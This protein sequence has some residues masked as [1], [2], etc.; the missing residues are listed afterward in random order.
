[1]NIFKQIIYYIFIFFITYLIYVYPFDIIN[2]LLI[3]ESPFKVSS[4]FFSI[5]FFFILIFY[6]KTKNTFF[7]FKI[8]VHEGMG[9]GFISFWIVNIFLFFNIFLPINSFYLGLI[10]IILIF[11][12]SLLSFILGCLIYNRKIKITSSKIVSKIKLIFISDVH[13]GSNSKKHLEKICSKIN[14]L[15]FDLLLIGGDLI[16]S[17]NFEINNLNILRNIHKPILFVSGNHEYYLRDYQTKLKLLKNKNLIFL[18]NKSFEYNKINIVGI[19]DN[20]ELDDQKRVA[21][22]LIKKDFFN[23]ILVHKPTLWVKISHKIDL[24]LSGHTHNGQIFP[25]NFFVKFKFK[26]IYGLYEKLESKLYV[27]S[28]VG[29]WGPKMRLGSKNEIVEILISS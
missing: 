25:F 10:S 11:L 4:I 18:D 7:L 6:F 12:I 3:N 22:K 2:Y 5:L 20:Q 21:E 8:I 26:N 17:S 14:N 28:G 13:L 16:D 29:C 19:S 24:M 9:L 1:M 23:L 27:S 15:K